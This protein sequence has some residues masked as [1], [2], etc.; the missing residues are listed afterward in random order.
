MSA[1][2]F[3][4]SEDTGIGDGLF[5]IG[6]MEEYDNLAENAKQAAIATCSLVK[7]VYGVRAILDIL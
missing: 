6:T 4:V 1:F 3:G 5:L 7:H 2:C